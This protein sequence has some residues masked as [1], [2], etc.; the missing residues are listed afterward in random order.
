MTD[1][2]QQPY[3]VTA[4]R[5][6]KIGDIRPRPGLVLACDTLK[7]AAHLVR[8]RHCRPADRRTSVDVGLYLAMAQPRSK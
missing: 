5:R 6:F 3:L 2:S 7:E 8:L 1:A 4:L